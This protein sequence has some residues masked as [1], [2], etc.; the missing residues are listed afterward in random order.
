MVASVFLMKIRFFDSK[1]EDYIVSL[2]KSM[3]AKVLRT[4]DLLEKFGNNLGMP[5]S[6]KVGTEL[7]ELRIRGKQEIRIIYCFHKNAV[8]L[9][10][11][12]VKK[13]QKLPKNHIEIA[14]RR[15]NSIELT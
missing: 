14:R 7:F 2:E 3:I 1:I 9:L 12:F 8:V 15:F 5:H 10:H 6:K 11:A 4:L 13:T